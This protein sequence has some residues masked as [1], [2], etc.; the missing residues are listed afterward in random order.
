VNHIGMH[1][2]QREIGI[3]RHLSDIGLTGGNIRY[4]DELAFEL[5]GPDFQF[6]TIL[7]GA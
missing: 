7:C 1:P 3:G 5:F 6:I 4:N 2:A